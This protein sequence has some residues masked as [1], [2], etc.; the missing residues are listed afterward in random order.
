LVLEI[1]GQRGGQL[2]YDSE[3]EA[4]GVPDLEKAIAP[5]NVK[6]SGK[7]ARLVGLLGR[8]ILQHATLTYN[9]PGGWYEVNFD[10]TSLMK[11]SQT[12]QPSSKI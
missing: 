8:D 9:G 6:H 3:I 12:G 2:R 4:Q 1:S 11:A 7:A 10:L 5:Y